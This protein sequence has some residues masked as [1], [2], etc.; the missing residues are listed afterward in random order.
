MTTSGAVTSTGNMSGN[1]L[2][3]RVATGTAPL[4][5]TSTTLVPNLNASLLGGKAASAFALANGSPNYIQNGTSLQGFASF[6]IDGDAIRGRLGIGALLC[7]PGK[8]GDD[9]RQSE[10]L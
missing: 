2:I 3:S 7:Q 10:R 5:V 6:N 1:R 8:H 9:D 4:Q